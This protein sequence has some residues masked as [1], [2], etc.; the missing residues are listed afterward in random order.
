MHSFIEILSKNLSVKF[1][2]IRRSNYQ[3]KKEIKNKT[4]FRK[5]P[6]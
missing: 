1:Y 5:Q 2:Y 3:A 4:S 6:K